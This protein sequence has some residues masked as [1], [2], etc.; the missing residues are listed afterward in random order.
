MM[1]L[2]NNSFA[3][4]RLPTPI[5]SPVVPSFLHDVSPPLLSCLLFELDWGEVVIFWFVL[6]GLHEIWSWSR[7]LWYPR[8]SWA[9][10]LLTKRDLFLALKSFI[11]KLSPPSSSLDSSFVSIH[12]FQLLPPPSLPWKTPY[13]SHI[14][15]LMLSSP[16]MLHVFL[17]AWDRLINSLPIYIVANF[18]LSCLLFELDLG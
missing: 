17:L 14:L 9:W 15:S 18:F 5:M 1:I 4:Q 11:S 8:P 7:H 6:I 16:S 2:T 12:H 3:V 10:K 13:H